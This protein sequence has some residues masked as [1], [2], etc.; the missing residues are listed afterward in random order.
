MGA[1]HK[2]DI[3]QL[4]LAQIERLERRNSDLEL[5]RDVLLYQRRKLNERVKNQRAELRRL[6]KHRQGSANG[7]LPMFLKCQAF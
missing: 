6:N 7:E 1:E 3:V 4:L 5:A 2:P